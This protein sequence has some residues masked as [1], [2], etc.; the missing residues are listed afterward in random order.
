V[1]AAG[2]GCRAG[3]TAV[4]ILRA[5]ELAAA[6]CGVSVRDVQALFSVEFKASEDGLHAAAR[7]LQRPVHFL[8][9]AALNARS[10]DCITHSAQVSRRAG[11][12]S[13]AETAA[14]AGAGMLAADLSPVLEARL[15]G[16]RQVAGAAACALARAEPRT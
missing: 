5:L 15:L 10:H 8:P 7:E 14:L 2:V 16:A 12:P 13:V 9:S 11:L 6:A 4:D 3:C 1:I